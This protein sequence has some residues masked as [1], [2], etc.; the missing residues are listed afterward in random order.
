MDYRHR[1]G[2][3]DIRKDALILRRAKP[4]SKDATPIKK[5]PHEEGF[6]IRI[7]KYVLSNSVRLRGVLFGSGCEFSKH[8]RFVTCDVSENFT[9]KRNASFVKPVHEAA[10]C[11][12]VQASR[13]VNPLDPKRAKLALL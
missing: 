9:V 12:A 7:F 5:S 13:S 10:I 3:D 6:E 4:V 8:I 1:G 11:E 2:N